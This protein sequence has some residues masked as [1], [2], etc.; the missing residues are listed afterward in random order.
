ML[1]RRSPIPGGTWIPSGFAIADSF[2]KKLIASTSSGRGW[3]RKDAAAQIAAWSQR[4]IDPVDRRRFAELA[5][6]ELISLHEGNFGPPSDRSP[7]EFVAWRKVWEA[8]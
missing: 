1:R 5:E 3:S 7:S 2:A 4:E 8:R 6:T